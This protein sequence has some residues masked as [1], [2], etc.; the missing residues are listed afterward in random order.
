MPFYRQ[1]KMFQRIG[2]DLTRATMCNWAIRVASELANVR[3]LLWNELRSGPT[4]ASTKLQFRSFG[5]RGEPRTRNPTSGR[6]EGEFAI[7]R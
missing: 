5:S 3:D 6:F 7:T 2:V 4:W 1:E